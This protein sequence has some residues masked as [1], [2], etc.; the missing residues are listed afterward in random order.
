VLQV[1]FDRWPLVV[2]EMSGD[3]DAADVAE[4]C[5]SYEL[6]FARGGRW[7][8]LV[9]ARQLT[10][11]PQAVHRR[12]YGRWRTAHVPELQQYV[13]A[14]AFVLGDRWWTRGAM[15][16]HTWFVRHPAPESFFVTMD[17][18]LAWCEGYLLHAPRSA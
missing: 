5:R 10:A 14:V 16:V 13:C 15:L 4:A 7:A 2:T 18:G 11:L 3:I 12:T 8:S 9:D 1:R 17:E 6:A